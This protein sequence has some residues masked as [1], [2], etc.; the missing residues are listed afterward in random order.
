MVG[1]VVSQRR[2]RSVEDKVVR[3]DF[4]KEMLC[5]LNFE[6][7]EKREWHVRRH[8]SFKWMVTGCPKACAHE[9][10]GPG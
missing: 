2:E 9:M 3:E 1:A 6:G 7:C 4:L 10:H 8:G 5:T